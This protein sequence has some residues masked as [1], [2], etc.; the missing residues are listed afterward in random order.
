MSRGFKANESLPVYTNAAESRIYISLFFFPPKIKW[1]FWYRTRKLTFILSLLSGRDFVWAKITLLEQIL[2]PRQLLWN[3]RD[4]RVVPLDL[5]G[6]TCPDPWW[7]MEE[8]NIPGKKDGLYTR[9]PLGTLLP[10]TRSGIISQTSCMHSAT[11]TAAHS[12]SENSN[13]PRN[14]CFENKM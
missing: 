1:S 3:S 10:S 7:W 9:L 13:L 14:F 4:F 6:F 8:F 5:A 11:P 2:L 12:F